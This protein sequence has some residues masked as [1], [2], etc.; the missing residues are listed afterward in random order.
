MKPVLPGRSEPGFTILVAVFGV[1]MIIAIV[2]LQRR[3]APVPEG[4]TS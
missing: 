4:K 1:G 3:V 2:V